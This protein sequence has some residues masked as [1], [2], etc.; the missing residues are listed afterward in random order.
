MKNKGNIFNLGFVS[1]LILVSYDFKP[2]N[3]YVVFPLEYLPKTHYKFLPKEDYSNNPE[4]IMKELYYKRLITHLNIGTPSRRQMMFVDTD[5]SKF[6]L[7][8]L[9]PP[10]KPHKDLKISEF[11]EFG[12]NLF[13]NESKSSSYR[14]EKCKDHDHDYDEVC[15][16]KDKIKFNFGN[17]SSILDFPI[18]VF[19]GEDER[20]PGMIGLSVNGSLVYGSKNLISELKLYNLIK[21]YYYFFD[22]EKFSPLN[23]EIKGN[24]VIGDL[25]HNIFPEKYSK[26]DL[27]S[28]KSNSDSSFWS[29]HMKKI[30]IE[31]KTKKDIQIANTKVHT[32]YEFYHVIGTPEFWNQIREFFFDKLEKENKCFVGKFSQNIFSFDDLYFYYCDLSVEKILL[33]N[34]SGIKFYSKNSQFIFEL[35]KDELYYKKG[36]YIYFNVLFFK[37]QYNDWILGQIFTSKYHFVFHTDS[38]QIS[39]YKKVNIKNNEEK[40]IS[41]DNNLDEAKINKKIWTFIIVTAFVFITI[42][43]IIGIVIGIKFL[44]KRRKKKAE[45]LVDEEYDYTPKN[46]ENVVN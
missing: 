6:F 44:K 46:E 42:G 16:A 37:H 5:T 17:Y 33:D 9:N 11:Y 2:S 28:L 39:F 29:Y 22:F 45:E 27:I 41:N 24:L 8:S 7:T 36:K 32:F 1:L 18:K 15:F 13:Y 20:I 4:I 31:S 12:E 19:K 21:D 23:S 34:L 40:E 25:P 10:H 35:T 38:R 3:S 30:E 26:E 43:I 14:E